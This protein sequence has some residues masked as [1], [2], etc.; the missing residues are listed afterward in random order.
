MALRLFLFFDS[1]SF[2][3]GA[4]ASPFPLVVGRAKSAV[5][6]RAVVDSTTED[7]EEAAVMGTSGAIIGIG[8]IVGAGGALSV[9]C[10]S[11]DSARVGLR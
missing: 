10:G 6:S 11:A 3:I 9:G 5:G 8:G 7:E 1:S 4:V 2:C